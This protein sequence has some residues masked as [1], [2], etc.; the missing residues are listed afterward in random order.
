LHALW[1]LQLYSNIP[2]AIISAEELPDNNLQRSICRLLVGDSNFAPRPPITR[3]RVGI[4][5]WKI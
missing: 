5:G 2:E 3:Y 1:T 4:K